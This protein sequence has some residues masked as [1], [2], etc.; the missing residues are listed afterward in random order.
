MIIN[1]VTM[2]AMVAGMNKRTRKR[3]HRR[4]WSFD[5]MHPAVQFVLMLLGGMI[6][7]RGFVILSWVLYA[8]RPDLFL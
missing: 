1:G 4:H 6:F 3:A 8:I 5:N 2:K 7:L